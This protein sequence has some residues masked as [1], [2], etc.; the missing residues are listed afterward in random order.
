MSSVNGRQPPVGPAVALPSPA[1]AAAPDAPYVSEVDWGVVSRLRAGIAVRLEEQRRRPGYEGMDA[2]DERALAVSLLGE[3]I[4]AWLVELTAAERP[5]PEP[6]A[7]RRLRAA[8]L[9]ALFGLGRLQPLLERPEV[10]NIHIQ[11][12]DRVL[13]EL[14]D[15]RWEQAP[16][17]AD[18]DAELVELLAIYAARAGQT[19][20]E[21]SAANPL[22][23]LRLP[24]GGP[25]GARLAAARE[26]TP[27]PV[28]AIRVHR[29][30]RAGL[31]D[32]L[33]A[34]M[35]DPLLY[36]FL[37]AAVLAG[38]NIVISG[39]PGVGKTTLLRALATEIPPGEHVVT[40]EQEY[41]L[42]LHVLGRPPLVTAME[43]RQANAEGAGGI[44][45]HELLT[46][47]LR[48]SPSRVLVG[49]VRAGEVT[50]ML[51]ALANGAAGGMCTIHAGSAAA[52][53][54]RIAQ[55]AQLSTP[56]LPAEAAWRFTADAVDLIL[57][58]GRDRSGRYVRE[59][60]EVGPV[61]ET[62]LPE[63]TRLFA[64][65]EADGRAV[66]AFQPSAG[67]RTRLAEVG[68]Q[69]PWLHERGSG[70]PSAGNGGS[71]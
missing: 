32:L 26:V 24:A 57:H 30:A 16:P 48:H 2:A 33:R 9:A 63:T 67:L 64:P 21:F 10:E 4:E 12:C 49:E 13:L 56:P 39:K 58:L 70:W 45:L 65:G 17:V 40:I 25:L 43:A 44:G 11:G 8:V 61:S 41:E 42:G 55:L 46:Q 36:E 22:L 59:V 47:A 1:S 66:P 69:V 51:A 34:G 5:A 27:R 29:L 23:N 38:L 18:S 19:A 62:P 53:P 28:V 20:R 14:A 6:E 54:T 50:A 60:L 71:W 52:V 15:G 3:E 68:F 7:E 37:R 35:V 31:E